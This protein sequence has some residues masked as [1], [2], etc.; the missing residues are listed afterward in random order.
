MNIFFVYNSEEW[1]QHKLLL[2]CESAV[3]KS[4]IPIVL[5][6]VVVRVVG[7]S[8]MTDANLALPNFGSVRPILSAF[9]QMV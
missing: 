2:A 5:G 4:N 3:I 8:L 6:K 9:L 7:L 1:F